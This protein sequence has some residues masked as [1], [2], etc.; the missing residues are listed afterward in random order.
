M[1]Q[2][3]PFDQS[4][5]ECSYPAT[6]CVTGYS[7]YVDAINSKVTV[8][9]CRRLSSEAEWPA[10]QSRANP[11]RRSTTRRAKFQQYKHDHRRPTTVLANK[12]TLMDRFARLRSV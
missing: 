7:H 12:T 5:F 11:E 3:L 10:R 1:S 8:L 4:S 9:S 6:I 2:P